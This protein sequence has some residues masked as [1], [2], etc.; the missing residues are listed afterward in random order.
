MFR[1]KY[2]DRLQ[3]LL[4]QQQLDLPPQLAALSEAAAR[5]AALRRWRKQ[6]WVVYSKASFAGPKKLL[7][8]LGRYTHRAAISN[9]R[10]LS[11]EDGHVRFTWRDRNDGDPRK[12]L[13]LPAETFLGRFLAHVLPDRFSRVRH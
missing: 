11:C 7:D 3:S 5:R 8:Y 4:E 9:H 13:S 2:L 10:I 6:A 1:G 12:T